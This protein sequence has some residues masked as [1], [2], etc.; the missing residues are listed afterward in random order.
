[1]AGRGRGA[2]EGEGTAAGVSERLL[3]ADVNA[4][5]AVPVSLPT[6]A[7][8]STEISPQNRSAPGPVLP[9][10]IVTLRKQL[11]R[12]SLPALRQDIGVAATTELDRGIG[13]LMVPV[14]LA[15]GVIYYF[16]L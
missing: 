11:R 4:V 14:F 10:S 16:S 13:F 15:A 5:E 2:G 9:A 7:P 3:F 12:L 1:M 6:P 8:T